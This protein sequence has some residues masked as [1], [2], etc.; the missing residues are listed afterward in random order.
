MTK[1][2]RKSG[3]ASTLVGRAGPWARALLVVVVTWLAHSALRS[4]AASLARGD[5]V[6]TVL[7]STVALI[8]S[9]LGISLALMLYRRAPLRVPLA[10]S[11]ILLIV[12][13]SAYGAQIRRAHAPGVPLP[14]IGML[15]AP[16]TITEGHP[17]RPRVV[18]H[19]NRH[20]FRGDDWEIEPS[21]P[22][23]C[24]I[25]DS[26]V[27]GSGVEWE[28][29]LGEELR[30]RLHG[31]EIINLGV[32]GHNLE[33]HIT[34][35]GFAAGRLQCDRIVMGLVIPNDFSRWDINS[36]LVLKSSLSMY[37]LVEFLFG[38]QLPA[39]IW[40]T[41]ELSHKEGRSE[42][43]VLRK[44]WDRLAEKRE[45]LGDTPLLIFTY[46]DTHSLDELPSLEGVEI[47]PDVE[48]DP[49]R[50]IPDDGHPNARG[51]AFFAR[52]IAD[53]LSADGD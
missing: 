28:K 48:Y 10:L 8:T 2:P 39:R 18:Y 23:L 33:S 42:R 34:M 43:A 12:F 3:R 50:Y 52:R 20:G 38:P 9:C 31:Y 1:E 49:S 35:Y 15:P 26:Y 47:L 7:L 17:G 21:Q 53:A 11:A 27:F 5:G 6:E 51:N 46:G 45:Y 14:S 36:E 29:T 22:R 40:N 13:G 4:T 25:G 16:G 44:Q 32:M 19:F 24:L 30:R 37:S 41:A